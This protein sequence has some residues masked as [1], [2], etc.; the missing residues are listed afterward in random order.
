MRTPRALAAFGGLALCALSAAAADPGSVREVVEPLLTAVERVPDRARIDAVAETSADGALRQIITD[1]GVPAGVRVQALT[2][3]AGY[4]MPE[5]EEALRRAVQ[6]RSSALAGLQVVELRA[7]LLSY[8]RVAGLRSVPVTRGLLDH[9]VPD[10][11]ADAA[12]AARV[13]DARELLPDLRARLQL[14]TVEFVRVEL[15]E[16]IRVLSH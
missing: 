6:D 5:N 9:A 14:E 15:V 11:R 1:T 2:A 7:G 8:A 16:S 12:R 10:V 13:A 3:L 4:P